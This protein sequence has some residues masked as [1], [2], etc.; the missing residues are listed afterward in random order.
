MAIIDSAYQQQLEQLHSAGKFNHGAK[1]YKIV[2]DFINEYKPT[3]LLDF[4]CGKGGLI[5][6]VSE[7]HPDIKVSGY[8]P[9]NPDFKTLPSE[10]VDVV[11]STDAIEHIEPAHLEA[12]LKTIGALM[13]RCG[14][15]RI[16]CYPAKKNLPDGR[17]AH[18]IVQPPE[19]WRE[20]LIAH[21]GV[22]IIREKITV[23]DHTD[24]WA[25]V[26]G[27]NYDVVVHK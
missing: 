12:T 27:H 3:T 20:Q 1:A 22:K 17:N 13:T 6:T 23:V 25:H 4:G 21:M 10:P 15:F 19:W 18:L 8:D 11:V 14:C 7:L 26:H 9:G 2:R 5:A 24:K 16:A